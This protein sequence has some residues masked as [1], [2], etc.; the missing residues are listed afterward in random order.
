ML[1]AAILIGITYTS[2]SIIVRSYHSFIQK[3]DEIGVLLVFDHLIK[4]DFERSE[5]VQKDSS[6]F[7]FTTDSTV[8]R[9]EF[10]PD[11]IIRKARLVDT[12]KIKNARLE[13]SFKSLPVMDL[14]GDSRKKMIDALDF[15]L[16]FQKDTID[17]HYRKIYSSADML[18]IYS[19][20]SD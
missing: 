5:L 17:R 14:P 10:F 19:N 20:A 11:A 13:A 4:R 3:N 7:T 18:K 15:V 16:F 12:F 6:G 1:I 9:Y 8:V 2:Y